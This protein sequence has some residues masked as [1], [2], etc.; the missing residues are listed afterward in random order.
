MP[1]KPMRLLNGC[2]IYIIVAIQLQEEIYVSNSISVLIKNRIE[3][4]PRYHPCGWNKIE[5]CRKS[6]QRIP[7]AFFCAVKEDCQFFWFYRKVK[8]GILY[9][10]TKNHDP[11]WKGRNS[12]GGYGRGV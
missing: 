4:P 5:G 6:Y 2:T 7:A 3:R 9:V 12:N 11:V 10:E 1:H 8:R